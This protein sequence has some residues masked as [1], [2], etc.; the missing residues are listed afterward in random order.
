MKLSLLQMVTRGR[1]RQ[2]RRL[3]TALV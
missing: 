3:D 1:F 2:D